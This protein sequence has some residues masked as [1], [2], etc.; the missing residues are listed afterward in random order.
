MNTQ[1]SFSCSK[2]VQTKKMPDGKYDEDFGN[3]Q[4]LMA[5]EESLITQLN[6]EAE[7]TFLDSNSELLLNNVIENQSVISVTPHHKG[8]HKAS[9]GVI[10]RTFRRLSCSMKVCEGIFPCIGTMPIVVLWVYIK[11]NK[12]GFEIFNSF[13]LN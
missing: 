4:A 5:K 7:D 9:V 3:V 6:R 12:F 10:F 2:C 13:C 11:P 1:N 8:D